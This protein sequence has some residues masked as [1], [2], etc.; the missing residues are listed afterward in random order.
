VIL[1]HS[2]LSVLACAFALAT[3]AT[4]ES[5]PEPV[6]HRWS[7]ELLSNSRYS[8]HSGFTDSL[9]VQVMA[10]V[11]WAMGR[12]PLAGAE[13][14]EL[15]VATRDNVYRY[16]EA[17]RR[18][19][20]HRAGDRRYNSGSAFEVGVSMS[21]PEQAGMA[22][23]AG[24]LAA[25][26]FRGLPGAPNE[27]GVGAETMGAVACPVQW[28][29]DHANARW[30][31][32][33]PILLV[34]VFGRAVVDALDTVSVA[35]ASDSSLPAPHVNGPDS[36]ERVVAGMQQ[37]TAFSTADL[38]PETI[39]QLAW[40]A[41]GATPHLTLHGRP[42]VTVPATGENPALAGRIYVVGRDGV[43]RFHSQAGPGSPGRDHRLEH[44]LTGDAR[45]RLRQA[46]SRVPM[47]APVYFAVCVPDTLSR[48]ARQE[49]GFAAFQLLAQARA[50]GLSGC[51]VTDLSREEQRDLCSA[52]ELP[53][54]PPDGG[55][56]V[57]VFACGEAEEGAVTPADTGGLVRIV[58]AQPAIRRGQLHLEYLLGQAG[59]VRVEVFDMLG[60]PVRL[61]AAGTQ[62]PGYH[63]VTWD[64]TGENGARLK[65][66]TYL[67]VVVSRG[68][69][70]QHKVTLG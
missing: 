9:P 17:G 56:P 59:P 39:S 49:A 2:V 52:L 64:G 44:I 43:G 28:A 13:W 54:G 10:N 18:L 58:R 68:S 67:V 23:E 21:R 66:G 69:V 7:F 53:V 25:T 30:N 46:C 12:V 15:Y 70:A 1:R 32:G 20:V 60:R 8:V 41:Y 63:S 65:R 26:A 50:L 24:L 4:A 5:L 38:S 61:L 42:G 11:L 19:T 36:F 16:D 3:L 51:V 62:S 40:A 22:M 6:F 29:T 55:L 14:R 34:G 45:P 31:P 47:T 27:A 48:A 33:R 35:W 37:D 57:V